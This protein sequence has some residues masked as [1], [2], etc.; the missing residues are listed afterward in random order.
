[1][2]VQAAVRSLPARV[3]STVTGADVRSVERWRAGTR[4]R[5]TAYVHRLD[6]LSAVLDLLGPAMSSRGKEAWLTSRSAHL[7]FARPIDLLAEGGFERVAG[8]A[9]AYGGG[10]PT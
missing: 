1:V 2:T 5:R 6:D 3:V 9:R 4:P 8:A 10:D 7:G